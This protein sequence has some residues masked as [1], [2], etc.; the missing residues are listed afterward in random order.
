MDLYGWTIC[1]G[2]REKNGCDMGTNDWLL[3]CGCIE[4]VIELLLLPATLFALE[5][6]AV[7]SLTH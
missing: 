2:G 7:N 4:P 1:M 3:I 6:E 5:L